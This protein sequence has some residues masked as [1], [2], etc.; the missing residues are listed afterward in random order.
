SARTW[1]TADLCRRR[2]RLGVLS[3]R[4]GHGGAGRTRGDGGIERRKQG[5]SILLRQPGIEGTAGDVSGCLG[6]AQCAATAAPLSAGARNLPRRRSRQQPARLA[7]Q[8]RM[9]LVDRRDVHRRSG[10][11]HACQ[12][13]S[14][15]PVLTMAQR[16]P[17]YLRLL[18][19]FTAGL[20]I[21]LAGFNAFIDPY[22]YF[23]GPKISGINELALGFNHRL[24]LAKS[25]AVTRLRPASV[26]LGNSRAETSYDPP[27]PGF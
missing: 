27:H 13:I 22:G 3:R 10:Q 23:A 20:T 12:R 9:G 1:A 19:A 5:R 26:I 4:I 17:A 24:P 16:M 14:L 7:P 18:A 15:L 2:G 8:R 25:L 6:P 21:A 11:S